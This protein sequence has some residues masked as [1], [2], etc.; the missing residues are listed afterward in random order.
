MGG[1]PQDL[2]APVQS[3]RDFG[4]RCWRMHRP[5]F[6]PNNFYRCK[7]DVHRGQIA[8][9]LFG[10]AEEKDIDMNSRGLHEI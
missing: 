6:N 7:E 4:Y 8:T 10:I 2:A 1:D 5:V 3:I 9:T